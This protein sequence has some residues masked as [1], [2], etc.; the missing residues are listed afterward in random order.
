MR[1]ASSAR[2]VRSQ[3]NG[4]SNIGRERLRTTDP[5]VERGNRVAPSPAGLWGRRR[6]LGNG[7]AA[8]I[9]AATSGQEIRVEQQFSESQLPRTLPPSLSA[10][11]RRHLGRGR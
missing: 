10:A 9:A 7:T 6:F 3:R 2:R 1:A 5:S 8:G 11:S 4:R